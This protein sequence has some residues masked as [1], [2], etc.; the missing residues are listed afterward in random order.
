[1]KADEISE[2]M[3]T[4][5]QLGDRVQHK[6]RY[7]SKNAPN[8]VNVPITHDYNPLE[9]QMSDFL[10]NSVN[11]KTYTVKFTACHVLGAW[12]DGVSRAVIIRFFF[13][14]KITTKKPG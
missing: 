1:M 11:Y 9:L 12:K 6:E 2:L 7:S 8:F 13:K 5:A 4:V 14:K 3:D 10:K